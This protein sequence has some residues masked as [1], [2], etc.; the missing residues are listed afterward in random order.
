MLLQTPQESPRQYCQTFFTRLD[1]SRILAQK[2]QP[3]QITKVKDNGNSKFES[4]A[5][6]G[7][8]LGGSVGECVM[9]GYAWF[10]QKRKI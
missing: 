9:C 6:S 1:N 10:L 7:D 8:G 2:L 5:W 3:D 4:S